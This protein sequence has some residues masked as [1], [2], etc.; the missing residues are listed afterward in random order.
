MQP[1]TI[2]PMFIQDPARLL[3]QAITLYTSA[4]RNV[5]QDVDTIVI[6]PTDHAPARHKATGR[7]LDL[8]CLALARATVAELGAPLH[9]IPEGPMRG[10]RFELVG[11]GL[12]SIAQIFIGG[13]C[14]ETNRAIGLDDEAYIQHPGL[15]CDLELM[16]R[17][18]RPP[19]FADFA[20]KL[21][22]TLVANP[23]A[24]DAL[25]AEGWL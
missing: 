7:P 20:A 6:D 12:Q 23:G 25:R 14:Q 3:D 13:I 11:T 8:A 22:A 18:P 4:R 15:R 24:A 10:T 19:G 16:A 2:R 9:I 5:G 17:R 1:M 21:G